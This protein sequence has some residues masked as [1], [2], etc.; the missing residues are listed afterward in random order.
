MAITKKGKKWYVYTYNGLKP[1]GKQDIVWS[2]GF[3]TEQE[4]KDHEARIRLKQVPVQR[5]ITSLIDFLEQQWLPSKCMSDE[6]YLQGKKPPKGK[7]GHETKRQYEGFCNNIRKHSV[8]SQQLCKLMPLHL[9]QYKA[10][11]LAGDEKLKMKAVLPS[12]VT[13]ELKMI[14]Q[15]LNKAKAWKLIFENPMD[16]VDLLGSERSKKIVVYNKALIQM[17]LAK[18]QKDRPK[19]YAAI[20]L[21][22]GAGLREAEVCGLRMSSVDLDNGRL[23][24]NGTTQRIKNGPIIFRDG[25][26]KS[27]YSKDTIP[28]D[29]GLIRVLRQQKAHQEKLKLAAGENWQDNIGLFFTHDDGSLWE[30]VYLN[31]AFTKFIKKSNLPYITFHE[32]RHTHAVY[33]RD[34][35]VDMSDISDR[36]R[37]YDSSFTHRKYA[38]KTPN[39][40]NKAIKAL[41]GLI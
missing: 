6:D 9:E 30:P 33:L 21:A 14:R 17:L 35:G 4:A 36:L 5:S 26:A 2:P 7:I 8:G 12:T 34:K 24:V 10:W 31:H 3:D 32:L 29:A 13:A 16:G 23:T 37:H 41:S 25:V 18:A 38:R 11:R 40:E 20:A 27:E 1:D 39:T 19:I 28:I 22:T 15:A